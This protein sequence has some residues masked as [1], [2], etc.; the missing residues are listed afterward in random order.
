[1][2]SVLEP[3]DHE[4]EQEHPGLVIRGW[5]VVIGLALSLFIYGMFAYLVI[6]DKGPPE[7][8]FG[9]VPD[10]PAQSFYSSK[11]G[12]RGPQAVPEPQHVN[13]KP[14]LPEGDMSKERK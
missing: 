12:I 1:M 3:K 9:T 11:P 7:W 6:G 13:E 10:I 4:I 5:L 8:D 14:R 2:G